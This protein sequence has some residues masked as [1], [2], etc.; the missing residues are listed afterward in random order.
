M[1][2]SISEFASVLLPQ[3]NGE[4]EGRERE[5][6]SLLGLLEGAELNHW[7][8]EEDLSGAYLINRKLIKKQDLNISNDCV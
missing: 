5:R 1:K 4:R 3:V 6:R 2:Q 7:I 8:A